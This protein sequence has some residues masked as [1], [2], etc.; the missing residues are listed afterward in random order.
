PGEAEARLRR[1]DGKY[2]WL[3][4]RA[5][6]LRDEEGNIVRWYGIN[7]DIEDRK[8]AEADR[9]AKEVAE[10]ANLAKD[11]FMANVSH[12]IRTPMNAILGMTELALE[13]SVGPEQR[14]SLSTVKSAAENLL[15]IIDDLL[16]FAK[17]EAGKVD[18]AHEAFSLRQVVRDCVRA[19]A[20]RA[21]R[22]G[23]D[24]ICDV[25]ADVP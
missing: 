14:L 11:E 17:I 25:A 5:S 2:R 1:R 8:Q 7:T 23:L 22:K 18:L 10:M 19:L 15:V 9:R 12:E 6:P 3:L 13:E 21:H 4:F 24:L 16:D 20:V